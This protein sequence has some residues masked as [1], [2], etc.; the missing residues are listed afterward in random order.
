[1][2]SRLFVQYCQF[3]YI[4]DEFQTEITHPQKRCTLDK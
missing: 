1:M 2:L 4:F 3:L